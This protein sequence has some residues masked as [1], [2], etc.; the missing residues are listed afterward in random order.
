MLPLRLINHSDIRWR[1]SQ[2]PYG[3]RDELSS[4][5]PTLR[6]WVR[7]LLEARMF[8]YVY[9]VCVILCVGSGHATD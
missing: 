2:W 6:L 4:L 3:L 8:V 5:A 7:I 9:A 1:R